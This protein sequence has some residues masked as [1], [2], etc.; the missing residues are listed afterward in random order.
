MEGDIITLEEASEL[1]KVSAKTFLKILRE[2]DL[3]ARKI[4]REWRF[5]R[6]ALLVWMAAGH[7]RDY[8]N[9]GN[10][11]QEYFNRV[12]PQYNEQRSTVYGNALREIILERTRVESGD[13]AV[14]VGAGTGYLTL[15]LAAKAGK[16][17]AV[18]N[19]SSML[20]IAREQ[21]SQ[22]GLRNIEFLEGKAEEIP[23]PGGTA[24]WAFANMLLHHVEDPL[25]VLKEIRRILKP[26][27]R[28]VLTEIEEH[29]H[30]WLKQEKS[31]LWLGFS[32]DELQEWFKEAGFK[33]AEVRDAGCD[34]CTGSSDGSKTVKIKTILATGTK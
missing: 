30:K 1:F 16:V 29:D 4:G 5:S 25:L 7:S 32:R 14:D 27:G 15:A 20:R 2:E 22:K 31:D 34:C 19:S 11:V 23:L 10:K 17:Y 3:P 12:A 28:I 9:A 18:D 26:G 21:A 13:V 33:H 6:Q 8:A 24:D